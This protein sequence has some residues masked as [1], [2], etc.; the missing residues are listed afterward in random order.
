MPSAA[1][2]DDGVN[3]ARFFYFLTDSAPSALFIQKPIMF[4]NIGSISE[5]LTSGLEALRKHIESADSTDDRTCPLCD[6][7]GNIIDEKGARPCRCVL[8]LRHRELLTS[9]RIPP[10]YRKKDLDNFQAYN[11]QL[12]ACLVTAREY[13]Q[14]YS[15]DNNRGL[16]LYGG[17]GL[18]KTHLAVAILKGLLLRGF[19]GVFYN[20][21][22]LFDQ[23]RTSI[24]D[25]TGGIGDLMRDLDRDILVLDDV[26]IPK[27]TAWVSDRL[28]AFVNSRYQNNKTL[29]ITT[30]LDPKELTLRLGD[31]F[32][33]RICA[34][35]RQIELKGDD[36]RA[37][38]ERSGK[39]TWP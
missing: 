26:T 15:P 25:D 17:P 18:G 36:Y 6:G 24:A 37:R 23:L 10:H 39:S 21:T 20:L 16:Y 1:D 3:S 33:S 30:N 4:R 11:P 13:V 28:Y 7:Y 22:D 38:M 35:C 19:D 34:M 27:Q 14:N 31:V 12:K 5:D 2:T 8:S 32:A 29:I 9:A